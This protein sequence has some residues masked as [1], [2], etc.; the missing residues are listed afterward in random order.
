MMH[1]QK[2]I[3]KWQCEVVVACKRSSKSSSLRSRD[4]KHIFSKFDFFNDEIFIYYKTLRFNSY[5]TVKQ[6]VISTKTI[7]LMLLRQTVAA[8]SDNRAKY[9]IALC[10]QTAGVF[11]C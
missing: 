4:S 5:L 10:G 9:I 7:R 6:A 11:Y 2:N 3:K 8:S 1:D